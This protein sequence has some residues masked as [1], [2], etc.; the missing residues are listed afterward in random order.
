VV[1]PMKSGHNSP[2]DWA[3]TRGNDIGFWWGGLILP[4]QERKS[5]VH[6]SICAGLSIVETT[7]TL[8]GTHLTTDLDISTQTIFS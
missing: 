3:T 1:A 6:I 8:Y 5:R 4:W 2:V 7:A